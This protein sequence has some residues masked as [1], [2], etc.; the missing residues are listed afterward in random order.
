MAV[1]SSRID[2][3]RTLI[4]GIAAGVVVIALNVPAQLVLGERVQNEMN[5]WMPG[6]AE[7]MQASG[8]AF[9]AGV[10]MKLAIG[11]ILVWLYAAARPR[12]GPGPKTASLMALTVWMLGA[13]YFS[14]FAL[15]GMISWGTYGLLEAMQLLA[16]L[17][18][19]LVGGWLYREP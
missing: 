7:R 3:P 15:I 5:A 4:G 13:I 16:F 2:A 10:V 17:A 14:D 8:T 9:A 1:M 18:A 19:A 6:A 11:V 12:L